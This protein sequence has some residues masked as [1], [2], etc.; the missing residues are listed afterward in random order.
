MHRITHR[1]I[2]IVAILTI[3]MFLLTTKAQLREDK[4]IT[5]ESNQILLKSYVIDAGKTLIIKPGVV[6]KMG[7]GTKLVIKGTLQV[8]GTEEENIVFTSLQKNDTHLWGW[9]GII[10]EEGSGNVIKNCSIENAEKAIQAHHSSILIENSTIQNNYIGLESVDSS[11]IIRN[12]N[13]SYN[14][15]GIKCKNSSQNIINN[16]ICF[17]HQTIWCIES[18]LNISFNRIFDNWGDG[19]R[20]YNST[21]KIYK[22]IIEKNGG[23]GVTLIS[24][25]ST[26]NEN[27][28]GTSKQSKNSEGNMMKGWQLKIKIKDLLGFNIDYFILIIRDKL[29]REVVN[30]SGSLY[31]LPEYIIDNNGTKIACTPYT[32]EVEKNGV[33]KTVTITLDQDKEITITLPLLTLQSIILII[34]ATVSLITIIYLTVKHKRKNRL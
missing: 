6:V 27:I 24:S 31:V 30:Q 29:D 18:N 10:I 5:W 12:N 13:I 17:N 3:M 15:F 2:W 28:F 14:F 1:K 7:A 11:G 20:A 21:V 23:Y 9:K 16:T 19:L 26:M 32:I 33:K 8:L 25:T 4:I 34:T 22:N